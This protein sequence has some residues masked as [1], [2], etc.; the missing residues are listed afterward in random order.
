MHCLILHTP[1]RAGIYLEKRNWNMYSICSYYPI[2]CFYSVCKAGINLVLATACWSWGLCPAVT[3]A[4]TLEQQKQRSSCCVSLLQDVMDWFTLWTVWSHHALED[5]ACAVKRVKRD[6]WAGGCPCQWCTGR[7][8]CWSW[9]QRSGAV[10]SP[11]QSEGMDQGQDHP[12]GPAAAAEELRLWARLQP[13][14]KAG[15]ETG[16]PAAG[17]GA[18]LGAHG[19][20]LDCR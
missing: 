1:C 9:L 14:S 6:S 8:Q 11:G 10:G 2:Q 13:Q 18:G 5:A 19:H 20:G 17:L 16:L 4:S 3:D 7:T 15:L 12:V